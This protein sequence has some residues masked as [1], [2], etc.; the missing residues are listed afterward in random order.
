MAKKDDVIE[1]EGKVED[2]LPTIEKELK[3]LDKNSK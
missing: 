3:E 1:M 2:V